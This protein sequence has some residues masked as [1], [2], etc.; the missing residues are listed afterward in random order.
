MSGADRGPIVFLGAG[1]VGGY[2]GGMLSLAG[3]EVILLD[4]WPAHVDAIRADGLKIE[5]P[6]GTHTVKPQALHFSEAQTLRHLPVRFAFLTVKLYDTDWAATLLADV[7]PRA[8]IVTLQNAFVEERVARIAG[9]TRTLG[10][11]GGTLDVSLVG[12]GHVRRTRK[13]GGAKPVFKAG[14]M[15]GRETPRVRAIAALLGQVDN[16]TV[17]THLWDDRW[18]KLCANTMTSGVSGV[19]G[20]SLKEVYGREDTRRIILRL[21]AEAIALGTELGFHLDTLFG[22]PPERWRAAGAGD[23]LAVDETMAALAAVTAS[24]VAGGPS[25]SLQDLSKGRRT[26][27]DFFNGYI[28]AEGAAHG[29]PVPTHAAV[30]AMVRKMEAGEIRPAPEHLKSLEG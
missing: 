9:W 6:E 7:V 3:E 12:P 18:E 13:R 4:P 30:A 20:L 24:M 23:R 29:V 27:V 10:V 1:A 16:A 14:E 17:T 2:V 19:S 5:T 22:L 8:P 28:A 15:S 21:G 25:G 11:V 26:E